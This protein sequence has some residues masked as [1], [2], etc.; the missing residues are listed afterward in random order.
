MANRVDLY[1][2]D[3]GAAR[4]P[5]RA[6]TVLD[7]FARARSDILAK[8]LRG[9]V[10]SECSFRSMAQSIGYQDRCDRRIMFE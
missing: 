6:M 8:P 9:G 10:S 1:C 5:K 4:G 3:G 2:C 7:D